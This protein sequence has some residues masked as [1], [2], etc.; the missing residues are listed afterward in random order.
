MQQLGDQFGETVNLSVRQGDEIVY[1]ERTAS[2][3]GMMRVAQIIGARAPLHITAAGKVFLL[4]DGP[5]AVARYA[6]RTG[7]PR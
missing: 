2:T 1:V 7:L 5:E 3:H 4:E 6:A